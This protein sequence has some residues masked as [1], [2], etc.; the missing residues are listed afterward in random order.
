MTPEQREMVLGMLQA[1][2]DH[3]RGVDIARRDDDP[4]AAFKARFRVG[5]VEAAAA[6]LTP[7]A[8]RDRR[9]GAA[10]RW[11]TCSRCGSSG[12]LPASPGPMP[13]H[14]DGCFS[15]LR[16]TI[17]AALREEAGR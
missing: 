4:V 16:A 6:L 1:D 9:V 15:D 13:Y 5:A 14:C 2:V 11:W 12:R 3:F 7:E 8:E 17:A 10:V